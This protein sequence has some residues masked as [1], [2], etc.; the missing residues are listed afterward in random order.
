MLKT[1]PG[2]WAY[3]MANRKYDAAIEQQGIQIDAIVEIL[4]A[5][6]I[7]KDCIND[8]E[9]DGV[10]HYMLNVAEASA[11]YLNAKLEEEHQWGLYEKAKK[12]C[13]KHGTWE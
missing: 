11:D 8:D 3:K 5:A 2:D 9:W 12:L 10:D 4:M 13:I 1:K 6:E 7:L